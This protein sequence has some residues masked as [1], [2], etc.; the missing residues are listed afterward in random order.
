MIEILRKSEV[1]A[2]APDRTTI[3]CDECEKE[4]ETLVSIGNDLDWGGAAGFYCERC[5]REA[6]FQL[7]KSA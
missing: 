2:T 7:E 1:V 6:L 3:C 4:A 5:L